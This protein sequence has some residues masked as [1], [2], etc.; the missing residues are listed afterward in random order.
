M[1]RIDFISPFSQIQTYCGRQ[2]GCRYGYIIT[3]EELVVVRVS[4]ELV[5]TG[6]AA[7]RGLREASG[8]QSSHSRTFSA[9]TISSGLQAMSLDT[10][11]DFSDDANP[12]IEYRPLLFKS[13]PWAAKGKNVL[14]IK[15]ALWFLHM[16][17]KK[18]LSVQT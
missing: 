17:T 2:W 12:N 13:I 14:T 16:E 8:N 9:E 11:S 7:L 6:L 10:G 4:R 15:L 1:R 3:P 5:G 18:D